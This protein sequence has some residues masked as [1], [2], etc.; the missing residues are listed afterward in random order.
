MVV[1]SPQAQSRISPEAALE[2]PE[3]VRRRTGTLIA[4][5]ATAASNAPHATATSPLVW[6]LGLAFAGS[7][8]RRSRVSPSAWRAVTST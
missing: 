4:P 6:D 1:L 3:R 5:S 8:M 2:A 7:A